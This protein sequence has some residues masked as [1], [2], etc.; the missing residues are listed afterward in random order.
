MHS[1]HELI[2]K[3]LAR[4][5]CAPHNILVT[6]CITRTIV[7]R[8]IVM[9]A[10]RFLVMQRSCLAVAAVLRPLA[11]QRSCFALQELD[12]QC[13]SLIVEGLKSFRP[14][15]PRTSGVRC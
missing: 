15:D 5:S 8:C 12:G 2:H 14:H 9:V 1:Q 6:N 11:K 7:M 3:C 10:L 13:D 4:C